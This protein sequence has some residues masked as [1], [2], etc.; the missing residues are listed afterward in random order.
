MK[1]WCLLLVFGSLV[2]VAGEEDLAEGEDG[3]EFEDETISSAVI[4]TCMG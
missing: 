1:V 4:E 3:L 2:F